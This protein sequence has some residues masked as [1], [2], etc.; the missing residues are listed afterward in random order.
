VIRANVDL[1]WKADTQPL[2][3]VIDEIRAGNAAG[4]RGLANSWLIC[5]LAE[6]D[7]AAA[8]NALIALGETPFVDGSIQWN[9]PL[10]EGLIARLMKDDAKARAAFTEAIAEQEK[11]VQAEPNHGPARCVLGLIYAA[12]GRK[13]EALREGRRAVELLPMERD[14]IR[15]KAMIRYLAK[16]AA[17]VGDSD[18]A[19]EQLAIATQVP[20][21]VTYGQL[22]LMPWWDPLRD[23]PCFKKIVASLAPKDSD[24]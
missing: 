1:D 5:A 15:G 19:C 23:D 2:H 7:A 13:D 3:Q 14:A 12:L 21:G 8:K 6:H 10:V 17:W 22:K 24:K 11:I 4:V 16:I 20:S 18:L 9:H